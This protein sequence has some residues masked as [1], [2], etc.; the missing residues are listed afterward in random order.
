MEKDNDYYFSVYA[1]LV[2]LT[3]LT[4]GSFYLRMGRIF[5]V[6]AALAIALVKSSL[7]ALYF[8]HL[9]HEKPLIY[10]VVFIGMLAVAILAIGILPDV[11]FK[12]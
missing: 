12:L 3:L 9:R 11:A 4:L 7:I 5:A 6:T 10:G 1:C 2:V 8:M